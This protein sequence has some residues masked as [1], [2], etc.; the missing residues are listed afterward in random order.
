MRW[1]GSYQDMPDLFKVELE[2]PLN[3]LVSF[4]SQPSRLLDLLATRFLPAGLLVVIAAKQIK[5]FSAEKKRPHEPD[6]LWL[7]LGAQLLL[8]AALDGE[9]AYVHDYYLIGMALPLCMLFAQFWQET[10]RKLWRA[11]LLTIILLR[12]VD[13][14]ATETRAFSRRQENPQKLDIDRMYAEC[15]ALRQEHPEIP[16]RQ[17][18]RFRS[19]AELFPRLGLC[20]GEMQNS[21]TAPWGFFYARDA[22]PDDCR[23]HATKSQVTLAACNNS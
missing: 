14:T 18:K 5:R 6:R 21:G 1:L 23:V 11:L 4:F 2:H 10:Q 15:R 7:I 19:S 13:I 17:G 12:M 22:L 20:F 16:W 3:N 9:H 8:L